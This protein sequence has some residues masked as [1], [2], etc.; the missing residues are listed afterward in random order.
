MGAVSGSI[1]A[2]RDPAV[3]S[4]LPSTIIPPTPPDNPSPVAGRPGPG[5]RTVPVSLCPAGEPVGGPPCPP[6]P[7]PAGTEARPT[8][9][10]TLHDRTRIPSL[11]G[12]PAPPSQPKVDLVLL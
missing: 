9:N 12:P 2:I 5:M 7:S 6:R 11:N 8:D 4:P 1:G 10:P 3:G